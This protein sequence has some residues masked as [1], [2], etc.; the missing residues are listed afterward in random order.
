MTDSPQ[1]GRSDAARSGLLQSGL[2][3]GL[4][5]YLI[6][7]FLP[8]LFKLLQ[9]V[10]AGEIVAQRIL[11]SLLFVGALIAFGGRM[12]HLRAA[13]RN[14]VTLRY[15]ALSAALIA[16]NWL[17]FIWA[18]LNNH[19]LEGSLG[20]FLNPLVNVAL[21][22]LLLKE[23]LGRAQG[24]AVAL[25]AVGVVVLGMGAGKGLWISITLATSFGIYGL[26]RKVAPVEAIEGLSI[27]TLLLLPF[28]LAWLAWL[29]ATDGIA[30]GGGVWLDLLLIISGP[31]TAVPLLLFAVAA[32]RMR[33]VTLGLL[34]YLAPT[35]NF[36]L[37]VFAYGEPLTTPHIIC[38]A[39]IWIGLAI[40]SAGA[41]AGLRRPAITEP[42][43]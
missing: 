25:A 12:A 28:A 32:R 43:G 33:Y 15:M 4:G 21:G 23:R 36:L 29:A 38:F 8:V 3:H 11:W 17:V 31:A 16:T 37:A 39:L 34:Q 27:E 19:L 24:I 26:I 10:S 40:Y 30:F 35:I 1:P 18:T 7:G 9:S 5:A 6:W 42:V 13:L 22:V 14:P 41:L 20:Y 2:A